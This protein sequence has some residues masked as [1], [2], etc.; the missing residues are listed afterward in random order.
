MQGKNLQT[1]ESSIVCVF[2][3][4]P[5]IFALLNWMY[6]PD[7]RPELYEEVKLYRN[8]REREK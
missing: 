4:F 2:L 3:H 8:A 5:R 6:I 1:T 7:T